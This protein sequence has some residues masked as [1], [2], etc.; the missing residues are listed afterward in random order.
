[1][2]ISAGD[3]RCGKPR[4]EFLNWSTTTF[5]INEFMLCANRVLRTIF[6]PKRDDVIGSWTQHFIMRSAIKRSM[7]HLAQQIAGSKQH[8]KNNLSCWLLV[9]SV[10]NMA[11]SAIVGRYSSEAL[12]SFCDR[13]WSVT[14][15]KSGCP[16]NVTWLSDEAN[17]HLDGYIKKR[18]F[19]SIYIAS[20]LY[21]QL[22][23][24][25][26]RYDILT[27]QKPPVEQRVYITNTFWF[28]VYDAIVLLSSALP[29]ATKLISQ[30]YRTNSETF[31]QLC[32]T[33]NNL[34]KFKSV[35]C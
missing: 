35:W 25:Q 13:V 30:M 20:V 8:C 27:S 12:L 16:L 28:I 17:F 9:V 33:K 7:L 11:E 15:G 18:T 23:Y 10:E 1:M 24:E 29:T 2:V 5:W 34:Y 3:V 6:V 32:S 31:I 21:R 19:S 22:P 4:A 26:I 14:G